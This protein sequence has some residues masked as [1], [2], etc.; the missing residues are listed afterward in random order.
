MRDIA[1][2]QTSREMLGHI[3]T[4]GSRYIN[5]TVKYSDKRSSTAITTIQQKELMTTHKETKHC[6]L[7]ECVSVV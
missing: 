7:A 5:R 1:V 2:F 4:V 3:I 6:N